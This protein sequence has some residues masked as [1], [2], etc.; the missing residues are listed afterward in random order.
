[1]TLFCFELAGTERCG[2][3]PRATG[4]GWRWWYR[5]TPWSFW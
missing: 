2:W 1:M 3:G 4:S 5:R